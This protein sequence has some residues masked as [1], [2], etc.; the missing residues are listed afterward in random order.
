MYYADLIT[1]VRLADEH[2]VQQ[3]GTKLA[4]AHMAVHGAEQTPAAL[5]WQKGAE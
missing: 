5:V 3:R 2:R 1:L 4:C